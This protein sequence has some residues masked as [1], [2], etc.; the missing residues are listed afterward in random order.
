MK[1]RGNQMLRLA[2][3][4]ALSSAGFAGE[5]AEPDAI[6]VGAGLSGLASALEIA[7]GGGRVLVVDRAS[8]FGGHAVMAMGDVCLVGTPA[9]ETR[10]IRDTPE[11]AVA[12]I[13]RWGKSASPEWV[14]LYA[15]KSREEIYDWL[16]AMG[17]EFDQVLKGQGSENSVPRVHRPKGRGIGLVGPV[18]HECLKQPGITF[19]W[20]QRVDRLL[21]EAGQVRGVVLTDLRSG[22]AREE[23]GRSVI[24]AT[25]G[26]QSNLDMV[27]EYWGKALP[28]PARFLAGS[29]IHSTGEG[30][31]LAADSGAALVAME[32]Q[33]N[34]ASGIPDP[35]YASG[36]RGLNARPY[37]SIW[38]NA[39]GRRF[40]AEFEDP[41]RE[42]P[43]LLRQPGST[44]WAIFDE[45]MKRGFLVSGSDWS[46]F[47]QI[48][49]LILA[50]PALTKTASTVGELAQ[51]AG[52]PVA[53]LEATVQ[54]YNEM[55]DAGHDAE[56]GRWAAGRVPR[57]PP[58]KFG[59]PPLYAVQFF[60]LT[61]KSMGGISI[62]LSCRVLAADGRII[63]GLYAVGELTGS[64]LINGEQGM[65]GMFLGPCILTG[66][67]AGRAVLAAT[68]P[69]P[70]AA[71]AA[72]VSVLSLLR[73]TKAD[74]PACLACHDLPGLVKQDR[75]G[76]W[77]FQGVHRAVIARGLDCAECHGDIPVVVHPQTHVI[78]LPSLSQSC[79]KCHVA[80]TEQ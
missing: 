16:V 11:L 9:Q 32:R 8:V 2:L 41:E 69:R 51:A 1:S 10:G 74:T 6:V 52:L 30:H 26:F 46:S 4:L 29:G 36:N 42:L 56:F 67:M 58:R 24:L 39:T 49:R 53:E 80:A 35:R 77:H 15:E 71:K 60:P 20:N 40:A 38:V 34:L 70:P 33:M 44:F 17:V 72:A 23:R 19:V 21:V 64:A 79:I 28:F 22:L 45:G 5:P 75:T 62:D 50:N 7:R 54:R 48:E 3:M 27:R 14:R 13:M 73:P 55:V 63:P 31:R 12:D 78:K 57:S 37:G 25:G 61:R 59:Q 47:A 68:A 76:Y 43:V 18:F 65:S 66:R